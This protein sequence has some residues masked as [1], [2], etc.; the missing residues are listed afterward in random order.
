MTVRQKH[1]LLAERLIPS[2]RPDMRRNSRT[3]SRRRR[4]LDRS[5]SRCRRRCLHRSR[6]RGS[7][8]RCFVSSTAVIG[9]RRGSQ[10]L[11]IGLLRSRCR[12][13]LG[14]CRHTTITVSRRC[15]QRYRPARLPRTTAFA[16]HCGIR[17]VSRIRTIRRNGGCRRCCIGRWRCSTLR[18][19]QLRKRSLKRIIR[20]FGVARLVLRL[21]GRRRAR[22]LRIHR[23]S[24]GISRSRGGIGGRTAARL[25]HGRCG[26]SRSSGRCRR[27]GFGLCLRRIC[28]S[29]LVRSARVSRRRSCSCRGRCLRLISRR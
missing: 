23:R 25:Q 1:H 11:C 28:L 24:S 22:R 12:A 4:T 5:T 15:C 17:T 2:T 20:R 19:R 6:M 29:R 7:L 21:R 16:G 18:I 10:L 13:G 27:C 3:A 9:W 26:R 14:R 8:S